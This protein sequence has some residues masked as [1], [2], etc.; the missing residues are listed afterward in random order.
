MTDPVDALRSEI[1]CDQCGDAFWTVDGY[2]AHRVLTGHN[3]QAPDQHPKPLYACPQNVTGLFICCL[4]R[5]AFAERSGAKAHR[6]G[7]D[8]LTEDGHRGH[9]LKRPA[10]R[11]GFA[12]PFVIEASPWFEQPD[13]D[14]VPV[15]RQH[16]V[17]RRQCQRRVEQVPAHR[18][19]PTP[20]YSLPWPTR[21][22]TDRDVQAATGGRDE[23]GGDRPPEETSPE[24]PAVAETTVV[25]D[26]T[27]DK[28]APPEQATL[29]DEF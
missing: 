11:D 6:T 2:V 15:R 24:P 10:S 21:R 3:Q 14:A 5:T 27:A 28:P 17:S 19:R 26:A 7:A 23:A 12:D 13:S 9:W 1:A 16:D 22:E 4:C 29:A 25:A 20:T 18:P 8:G